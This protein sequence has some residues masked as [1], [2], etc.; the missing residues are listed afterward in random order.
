MLSLPERPLPPVDNGFLG[1][2][3]EAD[4]FGVPVEGWS[5]PTE[6]YRGIGYLGFSEN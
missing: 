6:K 1:P 4:W 5:A 2:L 3:R